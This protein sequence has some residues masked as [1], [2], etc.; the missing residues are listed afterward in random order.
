[1]S[2]CGLVRCQSRSI[3]FVLPLSAADG[4]PP[5]LL[6]PTRLHSS[7]LPPPHTVEDVRKQAEELENSDLE[8]QLHLPQTIVPDY[9]PSIFWQGRMGMFSNA[10]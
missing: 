9:T 2:V 3:T 10:P 6:I 7:L 1:M 4:D 8:N 5:L